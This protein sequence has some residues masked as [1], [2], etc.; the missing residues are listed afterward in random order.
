MLKVTLPREGDQNSMTTPITSALKCIT[1]SRNLLCACTEAYANKAV[2]GVHGGIH[3]P[4]KATRPKGLLLVL[5]QILLMVS[6]N[7]HHNPG[8]VSSTQGQST[9]YQCGSCTQPVT[10]EEKGLV[11]DTCHQWYHANCQDVHS[12]T[13]SILAKEE[14]FL[15]DCIRCDCP[16]Y[17]STCFDLHQAS[18]SNSFEGLNSNSDLLDTPPRSSTL[19]PA[20]SSTPTRA[21]KPR[22]ATKPLRVLNINFQ[23]I[24][25]KQPQVYN[26]LDSTAPDVVIGTE[27]WVDNSIT[28]SQMFP[29]GY[30]LYRKDRNLH[31]GGVLIAIRDTL[32]SSPVPEL[33]TDCEVTWCR[34]EIAGGKPLYVGAFYN[35]KTS[36]DKGFLELEESLHR[37]GT[38]TNADILLGGDF[39][40]PD[41]DWKHHCLKPGARHIQNHTK[42]GD[43][44]DDNSLTQVVEERTRGENTLDLIATNLPA[45]VNRIETLPGLSDHEVVFAEM[46]VSA[47]VNKQPQRNIPLYKKA[48][49]D[50]LRKDM[51][52]L[53]SDVLEMKE[54]GADV[55]TMWKF[56]KSTILE[57]SKK[58]IPHKLAK[59]KEAK[60]WITP[61]VQR[62]IRRRDRAHQRMKKSRHSKD[63]QRFK[64]LK[65]LVQ[66]ELRRAYWQHIEGVVGSGDVDT[67][68]HANNKRFWTFVKHKRSCTRGIE[69]LKSSGKL[70]TEDQ[71]KARILNTQFQE[72]F[73][74]GTTFTKDQFATRCKMEGEF[75]PMKDITFSQNGVMK[76]LG[77]LNPHKAMGPDNIP[78]MILKECATEL[79][80]AVTAIFQTSYTTGDIPEDW[81]T[82]LVTPIYKKGEKYQAINYRP[83]SLTSVCCKIMEHIVT[84]QI[85]SH[86]EEHQILYPLQHG[87]RRGASCETQLVDF[88]DE[89]TQKLDSG[90]QTDCLIMDFSKAFDK[91][92]H[93]LLTHKLDHYGVRGSTSRWIQA[94]LGNRKQ[95]VVLNSTTSSFIAV[96]SGVP[97]GSVLGPAMF[98]FYINDIPQGIGAKVRLFADDTLM[99]LTI[100]GQSDAAALQE[101]LNSLAIWEEKW[102]MAFHPQKCIVLPITRN[103]KPLLF[104]YTLHGHTLERTSHAKYLGINITSTLNWSHH[105]QQITN[106]ANRTLGFLKRNVNINSV[107]I[108]SNA[109][110][111]LIRPTLE[112]ACPV[113]DPYTK[114]DIQRLEM[115]QRRS[116]RYVCNSYQRRASVSEMIQRIGWPSLATRREQARLA[117]MY[118]VANN[119]VL[120][121]PSGR[122]IPQARPGRHSNTWSY[123]LPSCK[124]EARRQSFFP[125]TIRSW[126]GLPEE[127][128]AADSLTAFKAVTKPGPVVF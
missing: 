31:G 119:L 124:T 48:R 39:N 69:A 62:L 35:P 3:I 100:K 105:I 110:K 55:S 125:R 121:D 66:R 73:S 70:F 68:Q 49:W 37:L 25:S 118:K 41:W 30:T 46:S 87:F 64:D 97:Q 79:A 54:H 19:R 109:Y 112:Y 20:H 33:D 77:N 16:Q 45:C 81:R 7:V 23:S 13:Y 4:A 56:F 12:K 9:I 99:Y 102:M 101:D 94:F 52:S 21:I 58:H 111:T 61:Q 18:T 76:L 88:V 36:N 67:G 117:L 51:K 128:V 42:L 8:P 38:K 82:A 78:P 28:D 47:T 75:P 17:S 98:L 123:H 11:C 10:W 2:Q 15:W 114:S 5:I 90:H 89:V 113:W 116:A 95:A 27:T 85:M 26:L 60:P 115:V 65:R 44:L 34:L 108:K 57:S 80:P 59:R 22:A 86:A 74:P 71:D 63:A 84:S 53:S 104:N 29:V 93:S 1:A 107:K 103:R 14:S 126:N 122:L 106:K 120:I 72:A 96:E 32:I 127:A 6:G 83:I 24:K 91:V 50:D 92:N 43:I 40:L